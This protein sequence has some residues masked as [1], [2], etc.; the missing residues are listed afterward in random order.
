[1]K[2]K[3]DPSAPGSSRD[4]KRGPSSVGTGGS[5]NLPPP[6]QGTGLIQE[7]E[8]IAFLKDRIVT[9]KDLLAHFKLRLRDDRNKK[10]IQNIVKKVGQMMGGNVTL[11]EGIA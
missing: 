1:M 9:T 5:S 11:K 3:L 8:I 6:D 2:R 4:P 10:L 7:A